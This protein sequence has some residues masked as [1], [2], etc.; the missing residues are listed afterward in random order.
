MWYDLPLTAAL[1]L[2]PIH[3]SLR[4]SCNANAGSTP[5]S[6]ATEYT[7]IPY[8]LINTMATLYTFTFEIASPSGYNLNQ[9]VAK[10]AEFFLD[11]T[12]R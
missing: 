6:F 5:F 12:Y 7:A 9:L 1:S 8:K 3:P 11:N 4:S 2:H 10:K